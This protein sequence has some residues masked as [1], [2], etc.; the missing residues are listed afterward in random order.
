MLAPTGTGGTG[1]FATREWRMW[2]RLARRVTAVGGGRLLPAYVARLGHPT[3]V[4]GHLAANAMVESNTPLV[5]AV[6]SGLAL[7]DGERVLEVGP[8]PG[9]GID[10]ALAGTDLVVHA[11]DP[12]APMLARVRRRHRRAVRTGR[13]R[14]HHGVLADLVLP[15]P[16]HAAWGVNVVYFL[17]DRVAAFTHL[18]DL[19]GPGGRLA[20]GYTDRVAA[21]TIRGQEAFRACFDAAHR[22][23]VPAEVEADLAAAGFTAVTTTDHDEVRRITSARRPADGEDG[24]SS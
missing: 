5:R 19:L 8:G 17:D 10:V 12:S 21:T 16:V 20:L 23:V 22:Q 9:Q 2:G 18:H 11:V 24:R 15:G 14:L 6:V 4:L 13:L 1:R 7:R 3:G